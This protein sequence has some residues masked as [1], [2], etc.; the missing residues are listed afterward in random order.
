MA[1][2]LYTVHSND[3]MVQKQMLGV[4]GLRFF[5]DFEAT[6]YSHIGKLICFN[7]KCANKRNDVFCFCFSELT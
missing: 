7:V 3:E 6:S 2:W 1:A 4:F 5:N